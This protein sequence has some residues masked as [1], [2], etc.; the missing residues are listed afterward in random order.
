MSC[1]K[2]NSTK[3]NC[4]HEPC[5]RKYRCCECLSFHKSQNELPACY[6]TVEEEKTYD[7]SI[8][9]FCKNHVKI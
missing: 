8:S 2:T 3:C 1:K 4:T 5:E 6:F 7:R 9:F